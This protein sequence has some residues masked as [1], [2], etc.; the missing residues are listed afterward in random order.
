MKKAMAHIST[1]LSVGQVIKGEQAMWN[2][3]KSN[4]QTTNSFQR[5]YPSFTFIVL[6]L[7]NQEVN[8]PMGVG[9]RGFHK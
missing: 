1:P 4:G 3:S 5:L 2:S 8:I 6:Y 9:I 7:S